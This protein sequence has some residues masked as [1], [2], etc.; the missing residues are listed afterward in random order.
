MLGIWLLCAP[1]LEGQIRR[2]ILRSNTAYKT[3]HVPHGQREQMRVSWRGKDWSCHSLGHT[4]AP[5]R[6]VRGAKQAAG[7]GL[8]QLD[9]SR[10]SFSMQWHVR[11]TGCELETCALWNT[12]MRYFLGGS[13]AEVRPADLLS[14]TSSSTDVPMQFSQL[15]V[16]RCI[17]SHNSILTV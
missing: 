4:C 6:G 16:Y 14:V 5:L 2:G 7:E 8:A 17:S 12:L 13:E 15:Y 10:C 3:F 9:N 11:V 1:S